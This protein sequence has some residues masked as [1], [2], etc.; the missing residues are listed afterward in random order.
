M[1]TPDFVL[2]LRAGVGHDLLWLPGVTA[3]V[4]H[5]DRVLLVRRADTGEW[6]P[7][8]GICDPGEHPAV[9]A[10]REC[11]EETGVV[12]EVDRLARVAV[13]PVIEYPNG[14]RTQYVDHVLRCRYV[15][16]TAHVADDESS[17]VGW[18]ALEDLPPM[19]ERHLE[20]VR[21]AAVPDAPTRLG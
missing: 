16:G 10:V 14:D 8:S 13:T 3:V 20:S 11:A 19:S 21:V 17:E 5:G 1:P 4:L 12:C 6:T 18:F 9:T 15:S 2:R 7:V